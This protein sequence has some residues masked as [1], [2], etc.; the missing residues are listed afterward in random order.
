MNRRA[1]F[2]SRGLDLFPSGWVA[3]HPRECLPWCC[4]HPIFHPFGEGHMS[5]PLVL[6]EIGQ[7]NIRSVEKKDWGHEVH[8]KKVGPGR[9]SMDSRSNL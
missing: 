5:F 2:I 1:V 4:P 8:K 6:R 9:L 3:N 7:G